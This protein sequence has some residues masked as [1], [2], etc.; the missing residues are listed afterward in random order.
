MKCSE[1]SKEMESPA[2]VYNKF[3]NEE[4]SETEVEALRKKGKCTNCLWKELSKIS[5]MDA[6]EGLK[7]FRVRLLGGIW[8][9]EMQMPKRTV[10][11][12]PGCNERL[13][14]RAISV[15]IEYCP[16][17]RSDERAEVGRPKKSVVAIEKMIG[18]I[19]PPI[20]PS[21]EPS[22]III[23][24]ESA[25]YPETP[26]KIGRPKIYPKEYVRTWKG[27][28]RG[29]VIS[30]SEAGY[31]KNELTSILAKLDTTC[32]SFKAFYGKKLLSICGEM[33]R[34]IVKW[35]KSG[36]GKNE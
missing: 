35:M 9:G 5:I 1:C 6:D 13:Y 20:P 32:S 31:D 21:P 15:G 33:E 4:W 22:S 11:A 25:Q 16:M 19:A 2:P 14:G 29:K 27:S 10:C 12:H 7:K 3:F 23:D 28:R 8:R 36:D 17:H 34:E 18:P 26:K 24:E 30:P